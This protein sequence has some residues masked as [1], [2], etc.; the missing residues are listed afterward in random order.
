MG[1]LLEI[2]EKY[3]REKATFL[4]KN[5]LLEDICMNKHAKILGAHIKFKQYSNVCMGK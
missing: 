3:R 1:Y 2:F 4:E 5:K